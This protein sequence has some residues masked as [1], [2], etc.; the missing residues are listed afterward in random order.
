V[1]VKEKRARRERARFGTP[2]MGIWLANQIDTIVSLHLRK[3][4]APEASHN[5]STAV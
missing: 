3:F 2:Y 5:R 4:Q 1:D